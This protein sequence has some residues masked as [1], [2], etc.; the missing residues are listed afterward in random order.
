MV[1]TKI[2]LSIF[3]LPHY[4]ILEITYCRDWNFQQ[5]T[6]LALYLNADIFRDFSGG[7]VVRTLRFHSRDLGL[8]PGEGTKISKPY[9]V[10][11]KK[12][13]DIFK[14]LPCFKPAAT[15]ESSLGVVIVQS[16]SHVQLCNPMDCSMPGFPVLHLFPEF[17]QTHVH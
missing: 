7:P 4:D 13:A 2:R 1:N 12:N 3:F 9:G 17:A 14:R 15:I 8:I 6:D 11:K 16:L 10:A 5:S